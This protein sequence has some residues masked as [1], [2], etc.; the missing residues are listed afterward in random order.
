[1]EKIGLSF[2]MIASIIS[3]AQ[4]I[5]PEVKATGGTS[6]QNSTAQISFTIGEPITT[7]LSSSNGIMT[8]GYQQTKISVTSTGIEPILASN[9]FSY[10]PQPSSNTLIVQ[11]QNNVEGYKISLFDINA[12]EVLCQNFGNSQTVID[13]NS[14]KEGV[15]IVAVADEKGNIISK[16]QV[17][18]IH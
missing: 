9:Q 5:T 4:T 14:F 12:Q 3:K 10:Y 6:Y 17:S 1:M 15:Y 18:I 8:Q 2:F 16:R 13:V 7:T 11:S